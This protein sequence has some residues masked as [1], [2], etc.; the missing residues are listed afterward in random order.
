MC[1]VC[2]S[3]E[4][5]QVDDVSRAKVLLIV[6]FSRLVCLQFCLLLVEQVTS[7][8]HHT[9]CVPILVWI[10]KQLTQ[11]GCMKFIQAVC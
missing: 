7:V 1:H 4:A 6:A 9:H 2:G 10:H 8:R 3:T 11:P 5:W